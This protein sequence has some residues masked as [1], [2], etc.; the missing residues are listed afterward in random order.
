MKAEGRSYALLQAGRRRAGVMEMD[1]ENIAGVKGS[2]WY[3]VQVRTGTEENIKM[4]CQKNLPR[5]VLEQCFIPYYEEKRKVQG[6]WHMRQK[7]LFPGY[8]FII[9]SRLDDL[10]RELKG[11]SG[12]TKLLGTGQEI[13]PLWEKEVTFLK[14]FGG[15]AQVVG[16]SEGIIE[17]AKVIIRS[18]PL[19]GFEGLI[20][21]IDRHK[22]RAW[23]E[24]PMF[25]GVQRVQVGVEIVEKV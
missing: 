25:G 3:V 21:K 22:R 16:M 7:I 18:G 15:P 9:T 11:I 10:Y 6:Q 19:K 12:L 2:Q 23:L 4:Q 20:K 5:A 13:V 8:V 17:G 1:K 24:L 14:A